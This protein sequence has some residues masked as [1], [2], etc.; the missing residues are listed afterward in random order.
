[1]EDKVKLSHLIQ[2]PAPA[3]CPGCGHL[4]FYRLILEVLEEMD[5]EKC[6]IEA[7]GIGCT[8]V[9]RPWIHHG[10]VPLTAHG[11]AAAL[12]TGIKHVNPDYFV[13]TFQGDGDASVI[14]LSETLN[15]AYRNENITVF[16]STNAVFGL[17]GGQMSWETLPGQITTTSPYGRDTE[18]TGDPLRVPELIAS[19]NPKIAYAARGTIS[20]ARRINQLKQ[21][22]RNAVEAQIKG[23]GY[24]IVECMSVCPNNWHMT[25]I[26]CW[27]HIE[28]NVLPVY[29]VGEIVKRVG[30]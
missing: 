16:I 21:M 14:G 7:N 26:Q 12:A 24:S 3:A 15:A 8:G 28:K 5:V 10:Y 6:A 17:T 13:F 18:S 11:R 27:E 1:M 2:S 23:E 29:P 22:I 19:L 30:D 9:N 25:P 4:L 20:G